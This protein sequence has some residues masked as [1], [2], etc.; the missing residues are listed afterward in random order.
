MKMSFVRKLSI[1]CLCLLGISWGSLPLRSE[2][3]SLNQNWLFQRLERG[4]QAGKI[5]NQGS[6][7]SSQY[8]VEHTRVAGVLAVPV[9]TL[10][11]EFTC[12]QQANWEK[13]NL[14]H[15][16]KLEEKVVL[17]QWQG[18]CYYKRDLVA[19]AD[20]KEKEVWLEFGAA[21]HLAD[22]W[23]NGQ[24][25]GQHAG[26]YLPFVVDLKPWLNWGKENEILVRL[27]NR[28]NGLIPP[29]KPL[30]TLDF[31]YYGGL[32][33]GV[34]L[35]VKGQQHITHPV[36]A[37]Q[38]AGG[39][40]FVRYPLVNQNMARISIQCEV[41]NTAVH[42]AEVQVRHT[43]YQLEG[44]FGRRKK[45]QKVEEGIVR[46]ELQTGKSETTG[47]FMAVHKPRLW[48]PD[49]PSLYLLRSE[50]ICDGKVTDC[51]ETRIGI[52]RIEM[53]REH[54]FVINGKPLRLVG[55]NRHMEYPYVGNALPENAQYR[56]IYQI[57]TNGFNIVR[58]GHYPQDPSVLEACDELGLLDD[59]TYSRVAVFQPGFGVYP[60]DLSGCSRFNP[61]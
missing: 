60:T 12:L 56:D 46:L 44:I 20:W 38:V 25:V 47:I 23:V 48:S 29:G 18:V 27:D 36:M 33:R 43:L 16:P 37:G 52:R 55:S 41:K 7:W 9:D 40:V 21:M 15:N 32:Y 39:G 28:D 42:S 26:G 14:P 31:C 58:L 50:V 34:N 2:V 30:N 8:N 4:Q 45:G 61:A 53:T 11:R 5:H 24:H 57:R 13:V 10:R 51:E 19:L 49:T 22:I 1:N 6:D 59:R 3:I 54:G 17:H 35:I